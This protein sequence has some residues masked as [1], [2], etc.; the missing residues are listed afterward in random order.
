MKLPEVEFFIDDE[1]PSAD[2]MEP[3]CGDYWLSVQRK[4][5]PIDSSPEVYAKIR[6]QWFS[7]SPADWKEFIYWEWGMDPATA[8][9]HIYDWG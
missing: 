8:S 1:P 6:A 5:I 9:F 3:P 4:V 2:S 7:S